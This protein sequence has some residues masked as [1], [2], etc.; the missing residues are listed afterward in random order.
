MTRDDT[1]GHSRVAWAVERLLHGVGDRTIHSNAVGWFKRH[2]INDIDALREVPGLVDHFLAAL[3]LRPNVMAEQIIR[4]RI[5][6][7]QARAADEASVLQ[8]VTAHLAHRI[9]SRQ[10]WAGVKMNTTDPR[11]RPE[12]L[13]FFGNATWRTWRVVEDQVSRRTA[14]LSNTSYSIKCAPGSRYQ[15]FQ[16]RPSRGYATVCNEKNWPS[17]PK[18][19]CSTL[20]MLIPKCG[21]TSIRQVLRYWLKHHTTL[22][23]REYPQG[24]LMKRLS[25]SFVVVREP[26]TRLLSAY[27]TIVERASRLPGFQMFRLYPFM[28]HADEVA[29]FS[30]FARLLRTEGDRLIMR[31]AREVSAC[32]KEP[33]WMHAM[34]QMFYLQAYPYPFDY[35][36]HLETYDSDL[37]KIEKMFSFDTIF[38]DETERNRQGNNKTVRSNARQGQS[39]MNLTELMLLAPK[40]VE[41]LVA[42]A[43]HDYACLADYLPQMPGAMESVGRN[44]QLWV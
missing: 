26:L 38:T 18:G 2:Q 14:S 15:I 1:S 5:G 40:A 12:C 32:D 19:A 30:H 7:G 43:R 10:P 37:T 17:L 35:V 36:A 24:E 3:Q 8:A 6:R 21:S 34:S 23:S 22:R 9:M 16:R 28:R 41:D 42:Y 13:N 11:V 20:A 25:G 27:G 31:E 33:V 29:R 44:P 4:A 39:H